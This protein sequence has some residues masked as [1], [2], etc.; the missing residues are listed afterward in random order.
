MDLAAGM[1]ASEAIGCIFG[2]MVCVTFS[3]SMASINTNAAP[4]FVVKA[5]PSSLHSHCTYSFTAELQFKLDSI[6]C[7][8]SIPGHQRNRED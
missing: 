6:V 8:Q 7:K 2:R 3:R 4:A 1:F 5:H